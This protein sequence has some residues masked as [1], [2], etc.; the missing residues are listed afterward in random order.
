M[1]RNFVWVC[2]IVGANSYF[3]VNGVEQFKSK[4]EVSNIIANPLCLGNISKAWSA[5]NMTKTGLFGYVYALSVDYGIVLLT[6]LI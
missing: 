3:F 5:T 6:F 1:V 2:I 4:A